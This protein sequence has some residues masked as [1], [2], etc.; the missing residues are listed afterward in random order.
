MQKLPAKTIT[1][2]IKDS[3]PALSKV[4]KEKGEVVAKALLVKILSNV[5]RFF[6]VGKNIDDTQLAELTGL[7]LEEYYF[8]KM[9]DFKI[10]G[11]G[12]KKGKYLQFSNGK[13]FDRL[14]GQIIMLSIAE[15]C[16]KRVAE[17]EVIQKES[18]G[19]MM[20]LEATNAQYYVQVGDKYMRD[21]GERV[22]EEVEH[23]EMA[24]PFTWY[25]AME[26]KALFHGSKIV[27]VNK[28]GSLLDYI[29]EK[30]PHLLTEV[31]KYRRETKDYF[32]KKKEIMADDSLTDEQKEQ[33][34]LEL[35]GLKK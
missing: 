7:I 21:N 3:S 28:A 35:A 2:A 1:E 5:I 6:N 29:E 32:I 17:A 33:K 26:V 11:N 14:D 27:N 4:K 22:V 18:T 31:E 10:W 9:A 15:Y 19:A 23:K 8:L 12:F 25:D 16:E 34:L 30:A 20:A 24:T 13:L